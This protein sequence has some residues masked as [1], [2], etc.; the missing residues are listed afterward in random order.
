LPVKQGQVKSRKKETKKRISWVARVDKYTRT[1]P[2]LVND[3]SLRIR[4]T[5]YFS[6]RR[7]PVGNAEISFLFPFIKGE[8]FLSTREAGRKLFEARIF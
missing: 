7:N 4:R 5:F 8:T 2:F 3:L 6:K 1:R